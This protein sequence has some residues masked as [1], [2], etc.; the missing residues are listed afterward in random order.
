VCAFLE[1]DFTGVQRGK[2]SN[3]YLL[4]FVETFSGWSEAFQTNSETAK[5]VAKKL[6]EDILPRCEFPYMTVSD[7]GPICVP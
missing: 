5:V 2:Y 6:L 7:N 4:A 3:K 1:I